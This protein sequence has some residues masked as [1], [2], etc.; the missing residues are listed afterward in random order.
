M[1]I[2][3]ELASFGKHPVR[4][5]VVSCVVCDTIHTGYGKLLHYASKL[6]ESVADGS[7]PQKHT[8]LKP[9]AEMQ[10]FLLPMRPSDTAFPFP[11]SGWPG[12][13]LH[14]GCLTVLY[15]VL[16]VSTRSPCPSLN[17]PSS[18]LLFGCCP[19]VAPLP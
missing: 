17:R 6:L 8:P 1:P 7:T 19:L 12:S 15:G 5:R 9:S 18:V 14:L 16:A 11:R 3:L 10:T 4:H 13:N 2:I